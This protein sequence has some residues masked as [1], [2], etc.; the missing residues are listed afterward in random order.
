MT[1]HLT[2]LSEIQTSLLFTNVIDSGNIESLFFF[3]F[4]FTMAPLDLIVACLHHIVNMFTAKLERPT[5]PYWSSIVIS[6]H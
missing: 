3:L 5:H 2:V 1:E 4:K 6:V